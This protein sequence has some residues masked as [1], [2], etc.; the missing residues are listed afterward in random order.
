MHMSI[1]YT[2]LHASVTYVNTNLKTCLLMSKDMSTES[3]LIIIIVILLYYHCKL[4]SK[5]MS[6]ESRLI[7]SGSMSSVCRPSGRGELRA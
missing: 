6:T 1:A 7:I 5:D 2:C 3:R 4:M